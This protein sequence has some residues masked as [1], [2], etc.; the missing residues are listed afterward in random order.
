MTCLD[1]SVH[2]STKYAT[3]YGKIVGLYLRPPVPGQLVELLEE[4]VAKHP[5][6]AVLHGGPGHVQ[7]EDVD[8]RLRRAE[9]VLRGSDE[10]DR[11]GL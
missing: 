4:G 6:V 11:S 2:T 3:R 7:E 1:D 5:E 8:G 9:H 10:L